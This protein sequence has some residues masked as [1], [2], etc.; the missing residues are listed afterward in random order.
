MILE[1][2][3]FFKPKKQGF[4]MAEER[5]VGEMNLLERTTIGFPRN[6]V[7]SEARK[8]LKYISL[9]LEARA[10][11]REDVRHNVEGGIDA[12]EVSKIEGAFEARLGNAKFYITPF[13]MVREICGYFS[14]FSGIKFFTTPGYELSEL[15]E[16]ELEAM[17]SVRK[18]VGEYFSENP[19]P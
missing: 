5:N 13:S 17:D 19:S 4:S 10:R 14:R 3:N 2:N 8:L 18:V 1:Y 16:E 9:K 7:P 15:P 11:Y 12:S 6:L